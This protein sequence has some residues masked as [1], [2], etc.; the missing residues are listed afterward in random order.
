MVAWG[1]TTNTKDSHTS[2]KRREILVA[3]EK[4]QQ[5]HKERNTDNRGRGIQL[6]V[7]VKLK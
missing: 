6:L 7:E 3:R 4:A 2:S 1:K 5:Y